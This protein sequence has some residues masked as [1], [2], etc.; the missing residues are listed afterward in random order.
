MNNKKKKNYLG[1]GVVLLIYVI[2][3]ALCGKSM[4]KYMASAGWWELPVNGALITSALFLL[5][6]YASVLIQV[7]IHEAGHL[8]FGLATGYRFSSFRIFQWMLMQKDGKLCWKRFS[9]PGTGGQ[10]L[11][12]PPPLENGNMPVLLYNFGGAIMNLIAS[13][14]FFGISCLLPEAS[15]PAVALHILALVGVAFALTNG[16][17][18]RSGTVDNDGRNA[19][20]ML[21]SREAVRA[22]WIQLEVNEQT[23]EGRRLHDMPE[24]WFQVPTD[25]AMENNLIATVGVL[26]CNRR[27][28]QLRFAEAEALMAHLLSIESG[29]PGLYRSLLT[30]DRIYV[31]LIGENRPQ[32]LETLLTKEQKKAMKSM[33][34][35]PSVLRTEYAI[36]LL[37]GRDAQQAQKILQR[38]ERMAAA[39]PTP[40]EIAEE[41]ELIGIAQAA[42]AEKT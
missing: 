36:A 6:F 5:I 22:F 15:L 27:M 3:G 25:D 24:E 39:Y 23:K 19:L 4:G 33:R 41:Q 37:S 42:A 40:G 34:Q 10:C 26:A 9:L 35:L 2:V 1:M 12:A 21:R 29:I 31:E 30:C 20:S 16:I 28:D 14:L 18:L 8:V 11:M 17:P 13:A 7:I 32:V 38:F